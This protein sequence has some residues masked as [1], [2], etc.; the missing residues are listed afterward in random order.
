MIPE[1]HELIRQ[2]HNAFIA[3]NLGG[4][5]DWMRD[6]AI[7]LKNMLIMSANAQSLKI[8]LPESWLLIFSD[9]IFELKAEIQKYN[10]RGWDA[11]EWEYKLQIIR[12]NAGEWSEC[13]FIEGAEAIENLRMHVNAV[14]IQKADY[15]LDELRKQTIILRS[16]LARDEA[17]E[18]AREEAR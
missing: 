5:R 15:V 18:E 13:Q 17:R 3:W 8:P 6:Q 10:M 2:L 12:E 9:F 11:S 4:K 14:P 7:G 1:N 16:L